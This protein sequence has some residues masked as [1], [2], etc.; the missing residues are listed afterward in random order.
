[1][2]PTFRNVFLTETEFRTS[3]DAFFEDENLE[4]FRYVERIA[5]S[6]GGMYSRGD[7]IYGEVK[8][9]NDM[10]NSDTPGHL[11]FEIGCSDHG[12][13]VYSFFE[14]VRQH[15]FASMLKQTTHTSI[16]I[17]NSC[18]YQII[19]HPDEINSNVNTERLYEQKVSKYQ[20]RGISPEMVHKLALPMLGEYL[21]DCGVQLI[22]KQNAI[23]LSWKQGTT[24]HY[25]LPKELEVAQARPVNDIFITAFQNG[26]L[27]D[28]T[29]KC[30]DGEVKAHALVLSLTSEYFKTLFSS[31]LKERITQ[32]VE[33]QEYSVKTIKSALNHIYAGINPFATQDPKEIPDPL[34]ILQ[35][36]HQ[37]KL[38]TLFEY[39]ANVIGRNAKPEEWKEIGNYG[40]TYAS[41]Y[42]LQVYNCYRIR[43]GEQIDPE[44]LPAMKKFELVE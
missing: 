8:W 39:A 40:A 14:T 37:W 42:L 24:P 5:N 10:R 28:T 32:V 13:S 44:F 12:F 31:G 22:D 26:D 7:S 41:K 15:I 6:D 23:E 4:R 35:L 21:A 43:H 2:E 9:L 20:G 30:A 17:Y 3:L 38:P 29:F 34:D 27:T 18:I 36:A 11:K 33:L 16:S 25:P 1:M 19:L